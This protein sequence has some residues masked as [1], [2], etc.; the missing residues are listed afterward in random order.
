MSLTYWLR[1]HKITYKEFAEVIGCAPKTLYKIDK[2]QPVDFDIAQ[3]V[4]I[5]TRGKIKPLISKRTS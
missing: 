5:A 4:H 1:T 3:K 2:M